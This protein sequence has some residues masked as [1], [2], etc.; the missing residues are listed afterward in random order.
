MFAG[1]AGFAATILH[2]MFMNPAEGWFHDLY[3][4]IYTVKFVTVLK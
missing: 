4:I 1:A 3:S 2:D